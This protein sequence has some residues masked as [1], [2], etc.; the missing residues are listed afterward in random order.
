MSVSVIA[1]KKLYGAKLPSAMIC[2]HVA[3]GGAEHE[4]R[5][6]DGR[7]QPEAAAEEDAQEAEDAPGAVV[8]ADLELEHAALRPADELG[9]L[10][11]EED[12]RDE[13]EQEADGA[14]V[15]HEGVDEEDAQHIAARPR[16]LGDGEVHERQQHAQQHHDDVDH[17]I[18]LSAWAMANSH[19]EQRDP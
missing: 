13:A 12:V 15:E 3:P 18:S 14:D 10:V 17:A 5:P 8:Q 6:A 7:R 9:R 1:G 19:Q 11:G 16:A 2:S 4:E